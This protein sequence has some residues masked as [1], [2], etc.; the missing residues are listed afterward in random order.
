MDVAAADA[1]QG[2]FNAPSMG[3]T[4]LSSVEN[5]LSVAGHF[6]FDTVFGQIGK[7]VSVEHLEI[8]FLNFNIQY[9]NVKNRFF[10]HS[11]L[12]RLQR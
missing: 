7:H 4:T 6:T 5:L 2:E 3:K 12:F 11:R 8:I 9:Y 1:V 10:E